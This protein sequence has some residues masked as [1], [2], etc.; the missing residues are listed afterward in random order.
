MQVAVA[1]VEDVGDA[2]ADLGGHAGDFVQHAREGGA[3]DDA[4]LH[5]V[6]GRDA[7][8]GGEGGFA[9]LPDEGALRRRTARGGSP[10]RRC[11]GRVR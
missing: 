9:A 2:E 1:G 8:H 7:A 11:C 4:V 3:G 6:V 10:R 5:D